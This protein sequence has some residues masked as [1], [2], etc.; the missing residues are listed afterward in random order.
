[1][2]PIY[3]L[4]FGSLIWDLDDLAPKVRGDWLM[5]AGP[6]F[7][8][9]FSSISVKRKQS[10]VVVIDPDMGHPCPSHAIESIRDSVA[11]AADD[12]A[13][14]ERTTLENIGWVDLATG[15]SSARRRVVADLVE[16]WC[17]KRGASGAVWTDGLSNFAAQRREAFTPELGIAY[18]KTLTGESL[19]EAVRYINSAP[20]KTDTPLRRALAEDSWWQALGSGSGSNRNA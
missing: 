3:I 15:Q 10:L 8:L 1:M 2:E 7:P 9:E 19:A 5:E 11:E 17:R 13:A 18:L 16:G 4:G 14:R 6:E 20:V 12:L